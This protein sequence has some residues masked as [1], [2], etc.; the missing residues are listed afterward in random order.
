[1]LHRSFKPAKCK[2]ALKLVVSRTKLLKNKKAAVVKQLRRELAQLLEQGQVQNARVRVEH[3]VREE[4]MMATFELI[5]IYC[6]L[7]ALRLQIIES[8][9]ECPIDLKEAVAS[10]IFATP[11][12]SDIPELVDVR[13]Q[14]TAKYGKEFVSAAIE[15]R[16][17]CGVNPTLV[18]KLSAK[19]PDGPAKVKILTA[20]AEE[21]NIKWDP[22]S[23]GEKDSNHQE[24]FLNA[25]K[26]SEQ[27]EYA[28]VQ[29]PYYERVAPPN[30]HIS[31][32]HEVKQ[33]A[34]ANYQDDNVR[35]SFGYQDRGST[36]AKASA[37]PSSIL[38]PSGNGTGMT[39]SSNLFSKGQ[40]PNF[41]N[42]QNW[43]MEF[44]DATA[45][46]QAAAESAERASMA[47]RAAAELSSRAKI[48]DGSSRPHN[49]EIV[50]KERHSF[51]EHT[52]THYGDVN[53]RHGRPNELSGA[54]HTSDSF[55]ASVS[56]DEEEDADLATLTE[57]LR[58]GSHQSETGT[59]SSS[60]KKTSGN[61][62][63][64]K[65]SS[66]ELIQKNSHNLPHSDNFVTTDELNMRRQ[67]EKFEA[68]DFL[69][70]E[71]VSNLQEERF[72]RHSSSAS[73]HSHSSF[74]SSVGDRQNY[75]EPNN[76]NLEDAVIENPF[77]NLNEEKY[78]EDAKTMKDSS[79]VVFDD[80]GSDGENPVFDLDKGP[81]ISP[82]SFSPNRKFMSYQAENIS[83]PSPKINR[84]DILGKSISGLDSSRERSSAS[85]F[86]EIVDDSAIGIHEDELPPV[87][88]D[89]ARDPYSESEEELE[90]SESDHED[91]F[92]SRPKNS[93]FTVLRKGSQKF[94][95]PIDDKALPLHSRVSL[96]YEVDDDTL[97]RHRSAT[98]NDFET[99][100][101]S[102]SVGAT[103]FSFGK[104]TGGL[105]N[106][107]YMHPPYVRGNAEEASSTKQEAASET[108]KSIVPSS[109][110]TG[111]DSENEDDAYNQ[112]GS[113]K[114]Q[115]KLSNVGTYR[116]SS[117]GQVS[118]VRTSLDIAAKKSSFSLAADK[119]SI[120]YEVDPSTRDKGVV[121]FNRLSGRLVEKPIG[122]SS[123]D[124]LSKEAVSDS[125]KNYGFSSP[126]RQTYGSP[127]E[128]ISSYETE[129]SKDLQEDVSSQVPSG[130]TRYG[131]GL[132]R[133]TKGSPPNADSSPS[134]K[135]RPAHREEETRGPL[136]YSL[137]SSH[138][139][140]RKPEMK[141][142]YTS[143]KDDV[144][145]GRA[146][147]KSSLP[148]EISL[149]T[150][151]F[152]QENRAYDRRY[153]TKDTKVYQ[154]SSTQDRMEESR[155]TSGDR[156]E[157]MKS[158][159]RNPYHAKAY[160]STRSDDAAMDN[161]RSSFSH[162]QQPK[163]TNL[164]PKSEPANSSEQ[165]SGS[166]QSSGSLGSSPTNDP[167]SARPSLGDT[168][169]ENSFN[170]AGHVHPKLPDYETV[171]AMLMSNRK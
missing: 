37:A 84:V 117:L 153:Y 158:S 73:S 143:Q 13:K 81:E 80:Y 27:V 45:A 132:S 154:I 140:D 58:R 3:V 39:E 155:P 56:E 48:Q 152:T 130:R 165:P 52:E 57:R 95:N 53:E 14:F 101:K 11:R 136:R 144:Q 42:Q 113:A 15:L 86:S 106:K 25:P 88:F 78:H 151:S 62:F 97:A 6:E 79:S 43:N 26:I 28:K 69:S 131:A 112:E 121:E 36:S 41:V 59:R 44:K 31:A 170:R 38:N 160:S 169:R 23:F 115:K 167:E 163:N 137:A 67:S 65:V 68:H 82:L 55:K 125:S 110:K 107:G 72:R 4:K 76:Q 70:M 61:S 20:I 64:N 21:H 63:N 33:E 10:V 30:A 92:S 93:E 138:S 126:R 32:E 150:S 47:A 171:F 102:S 128:P 22:N 141:L 12:C 75:V 129:H 51:M 122:S 145:V 5:E 46:A 54:V 116:R 7:I 99:S 108:K 94:D 100:G 147:M 105:R 9:K 29:V 162:L 135:S 161:K 142:R 74:S 34:P 146:E 123:E 114:T 89:D 133:R 1:M 98:V 111:S 96:T 148:Q 166:P 77:A 83:A 66:D 40:K 49:E 24:D 50:A 120:D 90:N 103:E 139:D 134:L 18:E 119:K 168:S 109:P 2:T 17:N 159:S 16:P 60:I 19:S 149:G 85:V 8:Q 118:A 124:P 104:L 35:S 87:I 156:K 164:K 157:D 127:S 91:N 71:K